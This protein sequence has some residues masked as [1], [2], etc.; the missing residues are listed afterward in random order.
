MEMTSQAQR[1]E[2]ARLKRQSAEQAIQLALE[3]KWEEAV[4]LNRSILAAHPTDVDAWNRQGKALNE[5]GRY[6]EAYESYGKSI[7]FDPIN[8]IAKRNIERLSALQEVEQAKGV[9]GTSKAAQDLFIEEVGKSGV[10]T[11]EATSREM[12]AALTAG[13]EVYLEPAESIINVNNA[14]GETIGTIEPKLG[15]RL[16]RL[17][18]GGNRYAAAVKSVAEIDAELIIKEIYKDPSQTRMSFPAGGREGVRAYTKESLLRLNGDDDDD[19]EVV[20]T[21]P[22]TEDWDSDTEDPDA[23]KTSSSVPNVIEADDNDEDT[24]D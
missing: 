3:G 13:D 20:D 6:R 12:L 22:E 23:A 9:D 7:G 21:E 8:T 24:D 4:T 10:T 1:E 5:L 15:L 16:L 18:D 2:A 17:I 14:Q 19:D 11:I